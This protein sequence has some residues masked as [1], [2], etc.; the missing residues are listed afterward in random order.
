MFDWFFKKKRGAYMDIEEFIETTLIQ[1][2]GGVKKARES[3]QTDGEN[4]A[5]IA[6]LGRR[7]APQELYVSQSE[8]LIYSVDFDIAVTAEGSS[9]AGGKVGLK[10][11]GIAGIEGGGSSV[12][13]DSVVSR[14]KF[15][16]PICYPFPKEPNQ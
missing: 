12:I 15:Q 14:V 4:I 6:Q 1:L 7:T 5:P 10:I 3:L 9:D 11:A 13:R 8:H 16:I 2:I